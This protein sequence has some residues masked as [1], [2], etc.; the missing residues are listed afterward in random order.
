MRWWSKLNSAAVQ[1]TLSR[2]LDLTV[3]MTLLKSGSL[4]NKDA[5]G[6][7]QL[8]KE[9]KHDNSYDA[10]CA[11]VRSSVKSEIN[12]QVLRCKLAKRRH[13][14]LKEAIK[15]SYLESLFPDLVR[16]FEPQ[17]VTYNGGIARIKEWRISCYLE[18]MDGGV[19]TASPNLKL[20]DLFSPLLSVCNDL[21]LHWYRQQHA[22]NT[23][24]TDATSCKRLMTFVTRYT[25]AP[26]EQALLKVRQ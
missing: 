3:T 24:R 5:S 10:S 8:D 22:C 23:N 14:I 20:L 21:F 4:E 9:R 18:V 13:L 12:K 25:P 7:T 26:G 1:F 19:P 15:P 11:F 6:T 17:T 16:L 2:F